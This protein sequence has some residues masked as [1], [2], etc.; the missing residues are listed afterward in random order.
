MNVKDWRS[1]HRDLR[2]T[3][4]VARA[5]GRHLKQTKVYATLQLVDTGHTNTGFLADF[6]HAGRRYDAFTAIAGEPLPCTRDEFLEAYQDAAV[7]ARLM[8]L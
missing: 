1:P 4:G 2:I 7:I 8:R 3:C 5:D 6:D